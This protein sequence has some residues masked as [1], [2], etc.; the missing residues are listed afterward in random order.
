ML[1]IVFLQTKTSSRWQILLEDV[2]LYGL[3]TGL[4]TAAVILYN[5][6]GVWA[7]ARMLLPKLFGRRGRA[8]VNTVDGWAD[9]RK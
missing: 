6:A 4:I 2:P 3:W 1:Y 7:M 9:R 5:F 8:F